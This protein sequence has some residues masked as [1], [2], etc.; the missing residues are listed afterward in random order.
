MLNLIGQACAVVFEPVTFLYIV[1]GTI[2]GVIFGA[3][4]GVSAAMAVVLGMTFSY[5]MKALPSIAFLVAIY[6][7]AITGGGITAVLFS[8]PGTPA[9]AITTLDGYPMAQRGE[10]GKALG[11]SLFTSA[12]GGIFASLCMVIFTSPLAKAAL[13]FGPAELFATAFLGL[14]I[15]TCLDSKNTVRTLASGM[16]GLLLACV[17]TDVLSGD[18][19]MTWGKPVLVKGIALIPTMVGLFA[20]VE[21]LKNLAKKPGEN[22]Y[23]ADSATKVTK[24]C[25]P[26]ELWEMKTTVLRS[27]VVGT[28]VG[29]LPGAGA[30]IASFLSYAIEVRS[31][32]HPERY[33]KGEPRGIAA[34]ETANNAATGGS[35]VPLLA[36]GI[37]GGN[38]AAIM[39][40]ALAVKGVSL[41]PLLMATKPVYL[42]TVFVSQLFTNVI[43]VVV[44]I[45]VAKMFAKILAIPYSI[46]GT[47][48]AV[49]CVVGAYSNSRA[50]SDVFLMVIVAMLGYA[51]LKMHFNS[52]ALVLG[53]VLGPMVEKNFRNAF[54]LGKGDVLN[55]LFIGH[56]IAAFLIIVCV[57][58]LL[59]P[60]ISPPIK[61]RIAARKA[62]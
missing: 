61:K 18:V 24:L 40:S 54:V 13:A 23:S 25:T 12:F 33:G 58:L 5:S 41:G 35:M 50:A 42:Y 22:A 36:L 57:I 28:V 32:K 46:L 60:V 26:R 27:A 3:M 20:L 21:I 16:I 38:V 34:S 49:L 55:S 1:I 44:A 45:F 14:S 48:I 53:L 43:M 17:G 9:S 8:I 37:P 4:P 52:A 19:R 15:L 47:V 56:P 29:I 10:G 59:W 62:G 51:F 6:C 2:G 7:A 31:S 39:A 11:I 30:I